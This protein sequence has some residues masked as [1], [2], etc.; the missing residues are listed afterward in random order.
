MLKFLRAKHFLYMSGLTSIPIVTSILE[1]S[2][3]K[4]CCNP[5]TSEHNSKSSLCKHFP[6]TKQFVKVNESEYWYTLYYWFYT[7]FAKPQHVLYSSLLGNK[8]IE[9]YHL[10]KHTNEEELYCIL[11]F[12]DH[13]N[14]W[15][16]I[17]HGG[18]SALLLDNTFGYLLFLYH[19]GTAVTANLTINYKSPILANSTSIL[20]VKIEKIDGRKMYLKGIIKN[21]E[22]KQIQVEATSLFIKP[23]SWF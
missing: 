8:R 22:T 11:Q 21:A 5:V 23:K 1:D 12:G 2:K 18:V 19:K 17:V 20:R 10:Y 9:E 7:Y 6:D 13:I 14:G 3:K 16:E 4:V 15:P